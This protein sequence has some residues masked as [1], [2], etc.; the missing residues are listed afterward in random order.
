MESNGETE[1]E[2]NHEDQ[3]RTCGIRANSAR[4]TTSRSHDLPC[5]RSHTTIAPVSAAAKHTQPRTRLSRAHREHIHGRSTAG[6]DT[7]GGSAQKQCC[8][9][10]HTTHPIIRFG[11]SSLVSARQ[12]R[13]Q[14]GR[15]KDRPAT[16]RALQRCRLAGARFNNRE[17]V[18]RAAC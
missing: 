6:G 11:Q 14:H 17:T 15:N 5:D 1:T 9:Q 4:T 10:P 3:R 2:T 16:D 8:W 13:E 18:Q 7:R 12:P